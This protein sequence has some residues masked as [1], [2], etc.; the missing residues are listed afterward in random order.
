[1]G[2]SRCGLERFSVRCI[3]G[4]R[5]AMPLLSVIIPTY[6]RSGLLREALATVRAQACADYEVIVVDDGSTDDTADVLARFGEGE[7]PGRFRVLRQANAGQGAARNLGIA[8]A[9][10][11]YCAFLDS[12]DRFFPWTLAIVAAAIEENGRPSVLL[13]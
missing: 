9:R 8:E 7:P 11:E 13:D 1:M 4:T 12:D 10:G 6:N 3:V 5:A 2:A